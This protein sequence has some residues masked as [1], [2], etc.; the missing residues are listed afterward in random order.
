METDI[1]IHLVKECLKAEA[2]NYLLILSPAK[3]TE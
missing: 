2:V 1:N 3:Q